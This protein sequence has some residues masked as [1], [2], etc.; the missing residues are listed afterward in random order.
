MSK[1]RK[2]ERHLEFLLERAT[3]EPAYRPEFYQRLMEADVY[4]ISGEEE[5]KRDGNVQM[6]EGET[7]NLVQLP[8]EDGSFALPFFTSL[9]VLQK[10]IDY[11]VNYVCLPTRV[12][13]EMTEGT[14][15]ILNPFS[16]FGKDFTPEEIRG[17]LSGAVPGGHAEKKTIEK[18]TKILL[19]QPKTYPA[20]LVESLTTLFATEPT[21]KKAYLAQMYNPSEADV[22]PHLVIGLH[23]EPRT[24]FEESL[25]KIAPV[26][27]SCLPDGD[28]VDFILLE[29][30][31][32]SGSGIAGYMLK[33]TKPF[34][35][36]RW[37]EGINM[38]SDR[39]GTKN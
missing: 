36:A 3:T 1:E 35:E 24:G 31:S 10:S 9:E 4:V 13:F 8:R 20:K 34:Y 29:P 30:S 39:K 17:L 6:K 38:F 23:V 2:A 19:G 22:K 33:D 26:A 7:V 25:K 14:V 15:L 5:K 16:E 21:V 18:D 28:V 12:L 27:N 32:K 11:P 37:S